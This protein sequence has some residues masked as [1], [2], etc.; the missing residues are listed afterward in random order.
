M[1]VVLED[2]VEPGPR[3]RRILEM[4]GTLE[5]ESWESNVGSER[6]KL[7]IPP[8]GEQLQSVLSAMA[9]MNDTAMFQK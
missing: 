7:R 2:L 6:T 1:L 4:D 3:I 5:S 9:G 8:G